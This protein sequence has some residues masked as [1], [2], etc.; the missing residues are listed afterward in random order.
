[1]QKINGGKNIQLLGYSVIATPSIW[2][3]GS[4]LMKEPICIGALGMSIFILYNFFINKSFSLKRLLLLLLLAYIITS[5]KSYISAVF[6]VSIFIVI[7]VRV[8][9]L[10]KNIVFRIGAVSSFS[11]LMRYSIIEYRC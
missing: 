11:F 8:F 4:G 3:W 2:L 5:V 9:F 1:M 6:A 10:I 7:I